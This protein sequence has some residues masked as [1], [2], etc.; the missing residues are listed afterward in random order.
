MQICPKLQG[1]IRAMPIQ[2]D[3]HFPIHAPYLDR[4]HY[5]RPH[6]ADH[7]HYHLT[8]E[9]GVCL[10]GSGIFYIGTRVYRYQRGDVS[11][12]APNVV[13]IAQ[14]DPESISGWKF[15]DV[16]LEKMLL[17]LSPEYQSLGQSAFSGIIHPEQ[18]PGMAPLVQSI[19]EE[20]KEKSDWGQQLVRLKVGELCVMLRRMLQNRA[21][22]TVLPSLMNEISTAVL[23][24]ANHYQEPITL[25]QLADMC[26]ISCTSFRRIFE[27]T[28]HTSPLEYLYHVR[29]KAAIN[30]LKTTELPITEVAS[31]VGYQTL[32]S[33]N[34]HF[35]RIAGASPRD[36]RRGG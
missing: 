27:R 10:Q 26:A 17:G 15:L 30:L 19:L 1:S 14:S 2:L 33:F 36:C 4:L 34:R 9:I 28:M 21:P 3:E 35:R 11:V 16:D 13:H 7:M 32:S 12:I 5:S 20:L 25:Q 31:R 18:L 22:L 24:I 8:T 23:Y 29:V 6:P